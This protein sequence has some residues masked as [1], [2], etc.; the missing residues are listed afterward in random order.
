MK[1]HPPRPLALAL[2]A[3]AVGALALA[4]L[5][6]AAAAHA[7][8]GPAPLPS[9]VVNEIDASGV[10]GDW[11]EI[12]N[13]GTTDV[14]A[15]GMILKDDKD[16]DRFDIPAGTTIKAGGYAS[17]QVDDPN[18]P[19]NFGLGKGGDAARLYLPD[20]TTLLDSFTWAS[21]SEPGSWGRCPDG[22]GDFAVTV[23][24]TRDA[25]N[26]CTP[27]GTPTTPAEPHTVADALPWPG[28]PEVSDANVKDYFGTN[29][30]GLSYQLGENGTPDTLWAV[31][32]GPSTLYKLQRSGKNWVPT[33]QGGWADGMQL[34]YPDGTGDPDAEGVV[35][36]A[37]G[38][39]VGT[40]RN[41]DDSKVSRPA[42]LR[43][44]PKGE[45]TELSATTEW[46]LTSDLPGLGAN[47]G[48]EG[49]G[50][51][52]DSELVSKGFVDEA[53]GKAYD[54]ATYPNHG[55]GIYFAGVEGT[56]KLY[57]YA[58][59]TSGSGTFTRVATIDSG[60]PAVMELQ[61]DAEK[62]GLW[63]VCDNTCGGQYALLDI[64]K[65]GA[66]AGK[67]AVATVYDRPANM[68]NYNNEGFVTAPQALCVDG[69]KP[70]FF[71]DDDQDQGV[72]LREG[73]IDCLAADVTSPAPTT[74]STP[75][76]GGTT[77]DG[78]DPADPAGTPSATTSPGA[79]SPA[80]STPASTT[81]A[82]GSASTDAPSG[83]A[84]SPSSGPLASTG[85]SNWLVFGSA[86]A[87]VLIGAGTS[88]A[89]T[90]RRRKHS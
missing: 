4:A 62:H 13:T 19:G 50:M 80:A 57:G 46:N 85:A 53:T 87:L 8:T 51:V 59:D 52:P 74:P 14:D 38:V 64:A 75:G 32:N 11:I 5:L 67:Y 86:A 23:S 49:L 58:L 42:I 89:V 61:Y 76:G 15:S 36:T 70:A 81:S 17:F 60:F 35:L 82:A 39:F 47:L 18:T 41:N 33:G 73:S 68:P 3:P 90:N 12:K 40:E 6:P 7:A 2:A 77:P 25:A 1:P 66:N 84:S 56:G 26:D 43:F 69:R 20:N 71:T 83:G 45:G 54:P 16:S 27:S 10:P 37:D 78:S 63:A 9:L 55:A 65:S 24:T 22:T 31:K 48:I 29:L 88:L 21:D 34:R 30:S 72:S 79:T 44:D 28:S